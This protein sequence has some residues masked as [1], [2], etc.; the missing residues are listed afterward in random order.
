MLLSE[1]FM[2]FIW[3]DGHLIRK[4]GLLR[5]KNKSVFFVEVSYLNMASRT[6]CFLDK[7]VFNI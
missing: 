4:S 3:L 7:L 2:F 1:I 5:R 6:D